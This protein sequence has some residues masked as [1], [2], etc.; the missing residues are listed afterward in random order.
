MRTNRMFI[1]LAVAA[2][3]VLVLGAAGARLGALLP[4]AVVLACPLMMIFMM[5]GMRMRGMRGMRGGGEDQTGHGCRRGST[6]EVKGPASRR[7]D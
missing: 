3:L 7:S 4:L 6:G 2:G 5:I 1:Y